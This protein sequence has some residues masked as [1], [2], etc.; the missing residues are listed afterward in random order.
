MLRVGFLWIERESHQL[1]TDGQVHSNERRLAFVRIGMDFRPAMRATTGIGR[2]V[3]ALSG[4]MTASVADD[5]SDPMARSSLHLYGVFRRGNRPDVRRP[6][7]GASLVAWPIP[8]RVADTLGRVGL[9]PADRVVGGCDVFHHTNYVTPVVSARTPQVMTIHDLAWLRAPGYHTT[10][11]VSALN[12]VMTRAVRR[13]A[14][15]CVP[16]DATARDCVELLGIEPEK[17]FVTPLGVE[18]EFFAPRSEDR[19]AP[20]LLAVGTIEPRKNHTRLIRA[21]A[22]SSVD[23]DLV[24]AGGR[25]WLCDE[26]VNLMRTTPRVRWIGHVDD[27]G[28]RDLLSRARA[29]VYPSL[30]EGFGL[31]VLEGLAA[32]TP[33][34]TSDK[35]PM[36]SVAGGA[37]LLVDPSNEDAL[38]GAM[39]RVCRDDALAADLSLRGVARAREFTWERCAAQTRRAYEAAVA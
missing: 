29:L 10:R 1:L 25:G 9:L 24:L 13:C 38:V 15:F 7:I 12:R 35:D 5:A 3:R 19:A 6:P 30:L 33:V 39:Q 20:F 11:A 17:I 21:F 18:R 27:I 14:A 22:R 32:G 4:A 26:T 37:A 31:P 23:A 28:L 16:S 36:R 2:Y 8:S 34:I